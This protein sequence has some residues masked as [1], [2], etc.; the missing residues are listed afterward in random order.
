MTKVK[1][2]GIRRADDALLAAELGATALGFIFWP[3]SARFIEPEEVQPIVERL[4]PFVTTVGV[5]VNQPPDF[6]A[7]V[8]NRLNLGAVQLHGDESVDDY[9]RVSRRL[10]K[11]VAVVNGTDCVAAVKAI[12]KRSSVLLDAHD[13]I[14]R[15]GTGRTIDW[16]QAA[17]ASRERPIIL[18]GGL[19]AGNVRD[20]IA[21]V[22]PYAI[23]VSS[24][25]ES[26]PG[27]KDPEKLRALFAALEHHS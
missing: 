24:G 3:S 25:V 26:S 27:I 18:S 13:P 19:T 11:A 12:P 15:G 21:A 7:E 20:A 2:C 22:G 23:D 16:M 14:K 6:V 5:F 4:P 9:A 1:I 17:A 8:A 10:I